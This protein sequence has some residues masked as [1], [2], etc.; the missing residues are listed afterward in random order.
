VGDIGIDVYLNWD[1]A[2]EEEQA[3]QI[4]GFSIAHGHVGYLREAYHGEPYA[5]R[6]LLPESFD[7]PMFLTADG[8]VDTTLPDTWGDASVVP[9]TTIK[10]RLP[11]A[12]SAAITRYAGEP[13]AIQMATKSL[14]DFVA[15]AE[16]KLAEGKRVWVVNSY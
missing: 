8:D 3:A 10:E 4:T 16:A 14:Q 12:V 9:I 5:T 15:L 11:D 7:G 13:E 2:T 1:G 6:V